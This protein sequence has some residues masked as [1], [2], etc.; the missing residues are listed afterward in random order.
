MYDPNEDEDGAR[1]RVED[2]KEEEEI[3][4]L[5]RQFARDTAPGHHASGSP[6]RP[7]RHTPVRVELY[8]LSSF[9]GIPDTPPRSFACPYTFLATRP[10]SSD[11]TKCLKPRTGFLGTSLCGNVSNGFEAFLTLN[12]RAFHP[13]VGFR[14]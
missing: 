7:P 9:F 13:P 12:P 4:A 2:W 3:A 5:S 14:A 1:E 10:V 6:R 11:V 8:R